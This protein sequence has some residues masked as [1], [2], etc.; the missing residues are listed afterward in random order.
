[1]EERSGTL[2][3]QVMSP[4]WAIVL[5]A[6]TVF[7]CCVQHSEA[8]T[9]TNVG[10]MKAGGR[11]ESFSNRRTM[12]QAVDG[13]PATHWRAPFKGWSHLVRTLEVAEDIVRIELDSTSATN[14]SMDVR[15][16]VH[17]VWQEVLVNK[18][19]TDGMNSIALP[20]TVR[21]RQIRLHIL[22]SWPYVRELGLTSIT[23]REER[24]R[25][26]EQLRDGKPMVAVA[27]RRDWWAWRG[28]DT[29]LTPALDSLGYAWSEYN[30]KHLDDMKAR[31]N[32]FDMVLLYTVHIIPEEQHMPWADAVR[33]WLKDGGL[34]ISYDADHGDRVRWMVGLGDEYMLQAGPSGLPAMSR[35]PASFTDLG[36]EVLASPHHVPRPL[37]TNAHYV[38]AGTKWHA[39][40]RDGMSCP[41][42][43]HSSLGKGTI[44]AIANDGRDS[45][46]GYTS[47]PMRNLLENIWLS[48]QAR[49][50][51]V[52][53]AS[54]RWPTI[55]PGVVSVEAGLRNTT[56]HARRLQ[57][58]VGVKYQADT[59]VERQIDL[60][61]GEYARIRLP[62]DIS[63]HLAGA[64]ELAVH[65]LD[66]A[67]TICRS[68]SPAY[69][70]NQ[71]LEFRLTHPAYRSTIFATDPDQSVVAD[72][73]LKYPQPDYTIS[74]AIIES[75]R[76]AI[77]KTLESVKA[78]NAD[79]TIHADVKDLSAGAYKL[80]A[81]VTDKNGKTLHVADAQF[82]KMPYKK[83]EI[84]VDGHNRLRIDG[85]PFF[86]IGLYRPP[87][88]RFAE[89]AE[90]GCNCIAPTGS[91]DE[92]EYADAAWEHGLHVLPEVW[93][94]LDKAKPFMDHPAILAWY[95]SDEPGGRQQED[96]QHTIREI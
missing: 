5:A 3:R 45:L 91:F 22:G 77:V 84:I 82:R 24:I 60:P 25:R 46:K 67:T 58:T 80:Q 48:H 55:A 35:M 17:Y 44:V 6:F 68:V 64:L 69:D 62:V 49:Q 14:L 63:S 78:P 59:N 57:V 70:V 72:V 94:S 43:V 96:P 50:T 66:H 47:E 31:L 56:D 34:L 41:T 12:M 21:A 2:T 8:E 92:V 81:Q 28:L 89:L 83:G 4:A 15:E 51:G 76:D 71:P 37:A 27:T 65:D 40:A 33:P 18:E 23:T 30:Y 20:K 53:V 10:P 88:D 1:M 54:L 13:D 95:I 52:E 75:N 36:V 39:L 7:A 85:K 61:P 38:L 87:P 42:A 11:F 93:G 9:G 86:P 29:V 19:L 79:F 73:H 74:T 90:A 32:D 26:R 16:N